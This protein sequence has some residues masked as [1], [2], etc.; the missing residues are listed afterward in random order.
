MPESYLKLKT[1]KHAKRG[2]QFNLE[3]CPLCRAGGW[4]FFMSS[5][6]GAWDCKKCGKS[7]SLVTLKKELGDM[8]ESTGNP[9]AKKE[10][11]QP[12]RNEMLKY[13][14]SL[15]ENQAA[16]A[17]LHSRGINDASI[18]RFRLGIKKD[19]KGAWLSIPHFSGNDLENIK[20]RS[21]PPSAKSFAREAGCKSILFN[22]S[23]I[24]KHSEII[25]TEGELDAISL[26]Q[27]GF[28]NVVGA[29]LGASGFD[30]EWVDLLTKQ[31]KIFL[32]YDSDEPGQNGAASVAKRLGYGR[33]FNIK[34]P[35]K[36]ANDF[37][38]HHN[39][40]DFAQCLKD[41]NDFALP[42]VIRCETAFDLLQA[43][44]KETKSG[45]V[46]QWDSVNRLIHQWAPGD[47]VVVTA[48]PKTGKT[49]WCLDITRDLVLQGVPVLF[50]CLE[51]RP[52][53][54]AL[55]LLQS[56]YRV[57]TPS[58][59]QIQS[60]K[61]LFASTPLYFGYSYK[62]H[63]MPEFMETLRESVRRYGLKLIVFDNLHYVCRSNQVNE[64]MAQWILAFKM[65]AEEME[66]PI[67]VIAQP[68]KREN[69]NE[70][71]TAEDVRYSSAVHSD[72]DQMIVLHRNRIASKAKDMKRVDFEG[73]EASMEPKTLVRIEAHRY[74]SGGE[75]CLFYHGSF[76]RF[77]PMAPR[78]MTTRTDTRK[79]I[80][81]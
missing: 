10:F 64:E 51:M 47:L 37:F 81:A 72:C 52:E 65:L 21:L 9:F 29:T 13:H 43:S 80:H 61:Q 63:K 7:G 28:E 39:S 22:Q 1:W 3:E 35:T 75:T 76:S 50:Y 14:H 62:A 67:I 54:L 48:L 44:Q 60:G 17:Y 4:H 30:V 49:T 70:V 71:M 66:L 6:T 42:G 41:A 2:T 24:A 77:D 55:K 78:N 69:P 59:F 36:D 31:K 19:E 68:R 33:C 12:D 18:T 45:I 27:N 79:D 16:L 11:K 58:I 5:E 73:A 26:I 34:L 40:K 38:Q 32:C 20:Y 23:A 15:S 46:T 53:R 8:E 74:G 57:E 56:Q 25:I